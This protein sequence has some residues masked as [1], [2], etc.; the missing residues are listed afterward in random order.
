MPDVQ[1][2][3]TSLPS[4]WPARATTATIPDKAAARAT[5]R[6]PSRDRY[7]RRTRGPGT[8]RR[9]GGEESPRLGDAAG[10]LPDVPWGHERADQDGR[11]RHGGAGTAPRGGRAA[12]AAGHRR[13][14]RDGPVRGHA[15]SRARA[16]VVGGAGAAAG[17]AGAPDRPGPG[18]DRPSLA[19]PAA[20]D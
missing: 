10:R 1:V 9:D 19:H 4:T 5:H 6:L 15:P 11:R 2:A 16:L 18:P 13:A 14:R 17:P 12:L 3:R 20:A 8:G 7:G